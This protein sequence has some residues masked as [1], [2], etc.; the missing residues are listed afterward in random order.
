MGKILKTYL[1][2]KYDKELIRANLVFNLYLVYRLVIY[3]YKI[4]RSLDIKL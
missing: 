4:V 1:Q 3:F 2:F